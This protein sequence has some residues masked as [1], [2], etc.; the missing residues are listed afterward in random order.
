MQTMAV[1]QGGSAAVALVVV[2]MVER[3]GLST[4][5]ILLME[6]SNV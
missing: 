5:M 6:V 2:L 3:L 1:V 4:L